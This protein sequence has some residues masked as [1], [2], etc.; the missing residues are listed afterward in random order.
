MALFSTEKTPAGSAGP[1]SADIPL[2]RRLLIVSGGRLALVIIA[3]ALVSFVYVRRSQRGFEAFTVQVAMATAAA[4]M[5][6]TAIYLVLLRRGRRLGELAAV[7][8]VLDQGLWSVIVYLTGGAASGATS[9]YGITCLAGAM[10]LG[11]QGAATAALAGGVFFSLLIVLLQSESLPWPK[12]QPFEN[13]QLTPEET[14]Y[15]VV[16]NLLV[17]VVVALLSGYLADRLRRAGGKL[18]LAEE[19]AAQAERMAA[20][21]RL[22]AGLAHEIRNPLSSISGSIQLL[23]SAPGL[24]PEDRVLCT[25][26]SREADRLNDLVTDMVDLARPR[27]P[28]PRTLDACAVAREVV[29]LAGQRGRGVTDVTIHFVDPGRPVFVRADDQQLRQLIWNLVRNAV[30]AS[31]AG[32]EVRVRVEDEPRA[33]LSVEDDGVG[34]D[35]ATRDKLFDA[36]FTTRSQGTGVGLAVVKRIADEHGFVIQVDAARTQGAAFVLDMGDPIRNPRDSGDV[37]PNV[38]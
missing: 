33:V 22:A 15:Y 4:A 36:F 31:T 19:R 24:G 5:V 17:L 38:S 14:T 13:Y 20:L 27:P 12:D 10:L 11:L 30:Q 6:L 28:T 26:I 1:S 2:S 21:G 35:P 25:L 7:Q 8:I 37:S 23:E 34:I 32:D 3:L 9:L 18:V 16:V 29:L